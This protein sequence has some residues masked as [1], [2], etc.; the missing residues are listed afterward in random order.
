[1][2]ILEFNNVY[3]FLREENRVNEMQL[4]DSLSEVGSG[5]PDAVKKLTYIHGKIQELTDEKIKE[6][7]SLLFR[8]KLDELTWYEIFQVKIL[9]GQDEEAKNIIMHENEVDG[10]ETKASVDKMLQMILSYEK[11]GGAR[12]IV[13][14]LKKRHGQLEKRLDRI[15]PQ[16]FAD[17][18]KFLRVERGLSLQELAELSG[19]STSYI[20]KLE[21]GEKRTPSYPIIQKIAEVLNID[22]MSVLNTETKNKVDLQNLIYSNDVTIDSIPLNKESKEC[23]IKI[24]KKIT[25]MEWKSNKINEMY[26]MNTLLDEYKK[27][28]QMN[29]KN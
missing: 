5:N 8:A 22:L 29:D 25:N 12:D 7:L 21:R 1:M 15:I 3:N 23:L 11:N 17:L 18:V 9:T 24:I 28:L 4:L 10:K 27:A 20:H 26:E 14:K 2:N 13:Q 6:Q 16:E 19:V